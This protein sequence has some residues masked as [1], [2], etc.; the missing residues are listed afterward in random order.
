MTMITPSH[1]NFIET[2]SNTVQLKLQYIPP[3]PCKHHV[4]FCPI[5]LTNERDQLQTVRKHTNLLIREEMPSLHGADPVGSI[6]QAIKAS[7]TMATWEQ[8]IFRLQ[9]PEFFKA[10]R[11]TVFLKDV[12]YRRWI[13]HWLCLKN[14]S[15]CHDARM[16]QQKVF[17][18]LPPG[19]LLLTA[20][21]LAVIT[22]L[23]GGVTVGW[24]CGAQGWSVLLWWV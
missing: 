2:S 10:Y 20:L 23:D 16:W 5:L 18:N 14:T 11:R 3:S 6:D 24:Q 22:S 12:W 8:P 21:L 13:S 17:A 4:L 1:P 9:S 7:G 15:W 19:S